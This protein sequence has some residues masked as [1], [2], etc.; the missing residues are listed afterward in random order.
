MKNIVKIRGFL[1]LLI[2]ALFT[3]AWMSVKCYFDGEIAN[4]IVMGAFCLMM[5]P[6]IAVTLAAHRE[7]REAWAA[8][9]DWTRH[10]AD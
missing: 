6:M 9:K 10:N 1:A 5:I 4:A 7:D 3:G 8:L 2:L